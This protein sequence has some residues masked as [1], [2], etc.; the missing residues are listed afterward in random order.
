MFL[1]FDII[2]LQM[3]HQNIF[4]SMQFIFCIYNFIIQI[5]ACTIWFSGGKFCWYSRPKHY[6]M[7]WHKWL[8]L[9]SVSVNISAEILFILWKYWCN[10]TCSKNFSIPHEY[11]TC[12]NVHHYQ[13]WYQHNRPFYFPF[14]E[15]ERN[16]FKEKEV[17]TKWCKQS[18]EQIKNLKIIDI[19]EANLL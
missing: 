4:D 12:L 13:H 16:R 3:H 9:Y 15:L 17:L 1:F 6:H 5:S 18:L 2:A 14:Q 10:P 19:I 7:L 11:C 8:N